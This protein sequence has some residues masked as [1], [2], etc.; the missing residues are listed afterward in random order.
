MSSS[1]LRVNSAS[2]RYR[3]GFVLSTALGNLTRYQNL[4]KFAD[5]D[6]DIEATWAP[7]TH[8]FAAGET[9]PYRNWPAPLRARAIVWKQASPVLRRLAELDAVMIHLFEVDVIT[10]LR[11]LALHR[12]LR[13]VSGD[14][15][16]A[17]D[18][19][20]YPLHP[21]DRAKPR[22]RRM[23]RLWID[24]WRARRADLLIPFSAWAGRIL[25]EEVGVSA[26]RVHPL[27]VGLDL[28]LWR[29][30]ERPTRAPGERS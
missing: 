7:V 29:S 10:A 6:T 30:G 20:A 18:P 12:P 8:Y 24:L 27:H 21:R 9:D 17:V 3:I 25:V 4:R 13:V 15:A 16:P 28:D 23:V 1:G 11:A 14:D 19:D 5:R 26:S 2:P 22:W